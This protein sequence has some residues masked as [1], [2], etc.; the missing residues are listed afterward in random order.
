MMF[1]K[2]FRRLILI[3]Y[4][5]VLS[6]CTLAEIKTDD[7]CHFDYSESVRSTVVVPF[8][9]EKVGEDI[10]KY[11]NTE[12]PVITDRGNT[13]RVVLSPINRVNG[14]M[15]MF[16]SSYIFIFNNCEKKLIEAF[17]VVRN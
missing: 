2:I 11:F 9:T 13:S 8:L 7:Y 14:Q 4:L 15:V 10:V 5:V 6:G 1:G 17:E 3:T 12:K 16:E